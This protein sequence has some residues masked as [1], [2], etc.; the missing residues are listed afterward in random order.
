MTL[1]ERKKDFANE[2]VQYSDKYSS[3]M[4][5]AFY[6]HWTQIGKEGR[7][8]FENQREKKNGKFQVNRRLA[9]WVKNAKKYGDFKNQQP[10]SKVGHAI[11]VF[12]SITNGV[13]GNAKS[14]IEF[15]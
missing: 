3:E 4:L 10:T 14:D 11:Q 9:T 6:R 15:L 8:L 2:I 5:L 13:N 12:N 1:E 7:M